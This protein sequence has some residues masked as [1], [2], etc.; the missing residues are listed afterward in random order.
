MVTGGI[1]TVKDSKWLMSY[2]LN[3][4]P[5]FKD[6]PKDQLVVWVY[7]LFTDVPGD[8]VKKPMRECAGREITEEWLYHLGVPVEEIPDMAAGSAHCV[9]CMMPYIT[10]FFMPGA[11]GDRPKVVPE[12]CTNFAFI[13]QFSDTVRDT[14]F[15]TEYSVRTAMEAVYT[16]LD[17]DRGVPEVFGSCYDVRVLLDSTSKMMDGKKL[18]DMKV[19]FI[20]N[21]VEKKAL[22][23]IEG[24][25]IEELL[26]R[27][28]VI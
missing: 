6:Q 11:E 10:A 8:N 17:V 19:P 20:L 12:G 16:L 5:H 28:H 26:E 23:K 18:T 14:V 3:R 15:T 27:Y 21:L 22:K 13:G 7:G 9:L 25:V 2:T 24:T 1:I 4:Q